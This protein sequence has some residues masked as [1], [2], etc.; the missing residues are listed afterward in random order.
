M[1]PF[2]Y[3]KYGSI[4]L[5]LLTIGY[6]VMDYQATKQHN[7]ELG[8]QVS[9]AAVALDNANQET[10]V[11]NNNVQFLGDEYGKL[12]DETETWRKRQQVTQRAQQ[13]A[14]QELRLITSNL[15]D[16]YAASAINIRMCQAFAKAS[17][18]RWDCDNQQAVQVANTSSLATGSWFIFDQENTNALISN[19]R[20]MSDYISQAEA[21]L[22]EQIAA[23]TSNQQ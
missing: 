7:I 8:Q 10:D 18:E 23:G 3:I 20:K 9:A 13:K 16:P 14:E 12:Q 2:L 17:G 5:V 21:G 1:N 4:A 19:I 22:L 11:A 15:A 6:Y